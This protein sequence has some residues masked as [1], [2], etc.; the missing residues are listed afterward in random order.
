MTPQHY[1]LGGK[2]SQKRKC[3]KSEKLLGS[4]AMGTA[5]NNPAKNL[6]GR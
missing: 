4:Q 5:K 2:K 1:Q 3:E 6:P